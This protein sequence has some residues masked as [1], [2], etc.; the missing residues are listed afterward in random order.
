MNH[1]RTVQF[2]VMCLQE[3]DQHPAE[4]LSAK[5]I[6]RAQGVPFEECVRILESLRHAGIVGRGMP[7]TFVLL[8]PVEEIT[9][10]DILQSVWAPNAEQPVFR[11]MY[12]GR[13]VAAAKT[14]REFVYAHAETESSTING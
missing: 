9:A 6:S 2:A 4:G 5:E 1:Q 7:G 10:M 3:L 12:V 8:R 14:T 11:L 13:R